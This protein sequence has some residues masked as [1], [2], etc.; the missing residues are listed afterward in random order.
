MLKKPFLKRNAEEREELAAAI[1][2]I[3][4]QDSLFAAFPSH[5]DSIAARFTLES[6]GFDQLMIMQGDTGDK[7]YIIVSG[8][9][10]VTTQ[11]DHLVE[12]RLLRHEEALPGIVK[13][14]SSQNSSNKLTKAAFEGGGANKSVMKEAMTKSADTMR[15]VFNAGRQERQNR[16]RSVTEHCD[17]LGVSG[18]MECF[19][20]M[21]LLGATHRTATVTTVEPCEFLVLTKQDFLPI[22]EEA[23]K[24]RE[25]KV[26]LLLFH[27]YFHLILEI[28]IM[29][30]SKL[31]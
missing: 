25:K 19:G 18:P 9:V 7:L 1:A 8:R 27:F 2:P 11:P 26:H 14:D 15:R 31:C 4:E 3:L 17:V 12:E 24:S 30:D 22:I 10:R 29:F 13:G 20:E 23:N 28:S 6:A 16:R 21:A 5:L